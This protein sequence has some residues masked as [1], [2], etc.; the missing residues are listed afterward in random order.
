M[1][2]RAC[3]ALV[4]LSL[5]LGPVLGAMAET[6][7]TIRVIIDDTKTTNSFFTIPSKPKVTKGQLVRLVVENHGAEPHSLQSNETKDV[8]YTKAG[9]TKILEFTATSVPILFTCKIGPRIE[10]FTIEPGSH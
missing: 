1:K 7:S 4:S 3:V 6:P 9:E 5:I 2:R 10:R 8:I